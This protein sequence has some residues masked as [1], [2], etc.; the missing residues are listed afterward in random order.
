MNKEHN[1]HG[2]KAISVK[3]KV[4]VDVMTLKDSDWDHSKKFSLL[5]M[6]KAG[7]KASSELQ[8]RIRYTIANYKV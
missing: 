2:A 5:E 8:Y 4:I 3:F 1:M 7:G 6:W